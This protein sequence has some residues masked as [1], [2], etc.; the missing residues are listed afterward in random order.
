MFP[1]QETH[2]R[3]LIHEDP[4]SCGATK[5]CAPQLLSSSSESTS[6]E[7]RA[8]KGLWSAT[9]EASA[10]RR[11]CSSRDHTQPKRKRKKENY[12]CWTVW[13]VNSKHKNITMTFILIKHL[14][15]FRLTLTKCLGKMV[16]FSVAS[17]KWKYLVLLII[18]LPP[19]LR[20]CVNT[21]LPSLLRVMAFT[22]NSSTERI[23]LVQWIAFTWV[24]ENINSE[25]QTGTFHNNEYKYPISSCTENPDSNRT[26]GKE[27]FYRDNSFPSADS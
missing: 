4:T 19:F 11:L 27:H 8:P 25:V 16:L 10:T 1:V 23:F 17:D 5:P 14:I 21:H 2:V 20:V 12:F 13:K 3:S 26:G 9:R 6:P 18:L 22:L 15:L 24:N 7:A